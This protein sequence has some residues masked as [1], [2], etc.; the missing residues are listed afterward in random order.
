MSKEKYRETIDHIC[1][2]LNIQPWDNMYENCNLDINGVSFTITHGSVEELAD[3]VFLYCD[4][5]EP[6]AIIHSLVWRRVLETNVV[7][8]GIT[9]PIF[10]RNPTNGHL[11]L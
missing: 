10:G 8:F 4:F 11:L 6:P 3:I 2:G 5:G 9:A 1:K 7:T